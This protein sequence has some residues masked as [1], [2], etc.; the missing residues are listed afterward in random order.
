MIIKDGGVREVRASTYYWH[1]FWFKISEL[2]LFLAKL[3]KLFFKTLFY[4]LVISIILVLF[5]TKG[6]LGDLKGVELC[7]KSVSLTIVFTFIVFVLKIALMYTDELLV[8]TSQD[9]YFNPK[10][11]RRVVVAVINGKKI[12]LEGVDQHKAEVFQKRYGL[13]FNDYNHILTRDDVNRFA[14]M[15]VVPSIILDILR[16]EMPELF[17]KNKIQASAR[18]HY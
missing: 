12:Y 4:S 5:T 9:M 15:F 10:I 11:T 17:I 13:Y 16:N 8:L 2:S 3:G 1:E 18:S 14:D 6:A 7:T